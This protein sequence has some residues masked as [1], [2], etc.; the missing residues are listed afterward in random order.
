MDNMISLI[1]RVCSQKFLAKSF[2]FFFDSVL[3]NRIEMVIQSAMPLL[4]IFR[5]SRIIYVAKFIEEDTV[6]FVNLFES[7]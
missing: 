7:I 2:V 3:N 5:L 1:V 6:V 4:F